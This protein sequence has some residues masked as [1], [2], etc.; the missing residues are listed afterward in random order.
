MSFLFFCSFTGLYTATM[1]RMK[2]HVEL[3][4]RLRQLVN[5]FPR[6]VGR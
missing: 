3:M 5:N 6:V 4:E 2:D 1:S